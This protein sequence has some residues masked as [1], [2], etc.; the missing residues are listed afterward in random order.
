MTIE[1]GHLAKQ[2]HG[3]ALVRYGDTMILA[4]IVESKRPKEDADFLPLYVDYRE[5]Y[6]A[7]GKIPGGFF[8]REGRPSDHEIL[9]ARLID[10]P[11]R[12]LFPDG[13]NFDMMVMVTVLSSTRKTRRMS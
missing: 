3:S 13:Y 7:G 4:A 1:T 8:K 10:R 12:P 6:S 5:R 9:A 2:A 11:I